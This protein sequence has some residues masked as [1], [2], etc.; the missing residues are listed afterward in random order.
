MQIGDLDEF[1]ITSR[2]F[3]HAQMTISLLSDSYQNDCAFQ[4]AKEAL[5]QDLPESLE[6]AY[7]LKML[8][9]QANNSATDALAVKTYLRILASNPEVDPLTELHQTVIQEYPDVPCYTPEDLAERAQGLLVWE[10]EGGHLRFIHPS[11]KD[12]VLS[13]IR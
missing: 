10:P 7:N 3:L 8:T 2:R 13:R 5:L 6:E 4:Q 1:R 9:I 11:A 12:Y